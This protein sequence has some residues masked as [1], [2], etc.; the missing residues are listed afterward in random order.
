MKVFIVR[1]GHV[2]AADFDAGHN[3]ARAVTKTDC[4]K[5]KFY[6]TFAKFT[7]KKHGFHQSFVRHGPSGFFCGHW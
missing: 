2:V 7:V 6:R 3:F 5:G 1:G 4:R